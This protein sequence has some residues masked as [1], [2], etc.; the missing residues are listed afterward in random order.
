MCS[1]TATV[2]SVSRADLASSKATAA[3][4]LAPTSSASVAVSRTRRSR[5]LDTSYA[6]MTALTI[7]SAAAVVITPMA[8][9]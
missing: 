5:E 6:I 4:L 9:N 8:V 3:R 7:T 2:D 1:L